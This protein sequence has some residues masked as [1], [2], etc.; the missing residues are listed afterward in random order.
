[1]N[2]TAQD[3]LEF[4]LNQS[5]YWVDIREILDKPQPSY[6]GGLND[7]PYQKFIKKQKKKIYKYLW[8]KIHTNNP[9]VDELLLIHL[10]QNIDWTK[11]IINLGLRKRQDF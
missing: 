1:M 7:E 11:L 6:I 3:I 10:N 5:E 2:P 8:K 4:H 9:L